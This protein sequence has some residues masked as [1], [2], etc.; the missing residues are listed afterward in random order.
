MINEEDVEYALRTAIDIM[1]E[2]LPQY[3]NSDTISEIIDIYNA[4]FD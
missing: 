4:N 1:E 3:D 2:Y